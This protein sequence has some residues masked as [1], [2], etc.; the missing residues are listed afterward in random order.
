MDEVRSPKQVKELMQRILFVY[1]KEHTDLQYKQG[2]HE[3]LS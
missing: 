3:L 2:M 1:G